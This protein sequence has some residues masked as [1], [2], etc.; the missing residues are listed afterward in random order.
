MTL[1][2]RSSFKSTKKGGHKDFF[3]HDC[4]IFKGKS[5]CVP[6]GSLRQSFVKEAHEEGLMG[7]F[8]VAKTLDTLDE[9]FF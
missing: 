6:Q 2:F 3:I 4:F 8:G 5:L 9:H 7:H 1:T